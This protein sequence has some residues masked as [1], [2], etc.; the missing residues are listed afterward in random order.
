M[1]YKKCVE[2]PVF[3]WRIFIILRI[4]LPKR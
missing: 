3:N 4:G 1:I 2:L